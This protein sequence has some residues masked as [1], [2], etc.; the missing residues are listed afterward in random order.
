MQEGAL[1]QLAAAKLLS[2]KSRDAREEAIKAR[3]HW[4]VELLK[5]QKSGC[6]KTIREVEK[7]IFELTRWHTLNSTQFIGHVKSVGGEVPDLRRAI[8]QT[9]R[10]AGRIMEL[11]RGR[12]KQEELKLAMAEEDKKKSRTA[13]EQSLAE[14][15]AMLETA[16]SGEMERQREVTTRSCERLRIQKGDHDKG[17]ERERQRKQAADR[18]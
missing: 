6:E 16:K 13:S 12:L 7:K 18:N 4:M 2:D 14:T 8:C 15:L 11:E 1:Q 5:K 9:L 17:L 10:Q 3:D